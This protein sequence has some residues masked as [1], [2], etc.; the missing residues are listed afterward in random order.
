M[1]DIVAPSSEVVVDAQNLAAFSEQS[2]AQVRAEKT[3]AT[4]NKDALSRERHTTSST[5]LTKWATVLN[6]AAVYGNG[7]SSV[8]FPLAA[9]TAPASIARRI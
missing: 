5:M 1:S 7:L 4:R 8:T 9:L 6:E 3:G 2:F